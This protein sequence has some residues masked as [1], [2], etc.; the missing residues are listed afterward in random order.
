MINP[1]KALGHLLFDCDD[2]LIAS[3]S[4]VL[5]VIQNIVAEVSGRK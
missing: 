4:Q 3:R 5:Q 2:T 1:E